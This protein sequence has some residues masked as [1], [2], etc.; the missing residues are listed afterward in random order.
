ME[1]LVL[2]LEDWLDAHSELK[3]MD[4][5]PEIKFIARQTAA[6]QIGRAD[7]HGGRTRGLY[8]EEARTIF[9]VRPWDAT[10]A[11][12]VSVLLH[13]LV[14]V[15]QTGHHFYCPGAQEEA[16]YRLQEQW[17]QERGLH[18][19]VNWIAVVLES[20]CTPNDIHPD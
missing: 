13:E 5:L 18:A 11:K 14:H 15:R 6:T 2:V 4:S 20:G 8:D 9:L 7:R 1:A 3:R 16:A 19:N 17:L 10:L 12:D